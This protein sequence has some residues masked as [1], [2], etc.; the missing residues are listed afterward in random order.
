MSDIYQLFELQQVENQIRS[1]K[2]QLD[3]VLAALR[4]NEAL[5]AA[6]HRAVETA[7]QLKSY[8]G[9]QKTLEHELSTL[10]SKAKRSENRLYSGNVKNPKELS[11]LQNELKALGR[12]RNTLEDDILEIMLFVEEAQENHASATTTLTQEETLWATRQ[13]E[14]EKEKLSLATQI[15]ALMQDRKAKLPRISANALAIYKATGKKRG[16]QAMAGLKQGRCQSCQV[17]VSATKM[18]AAD[19]GSL[20]DCGSCGKILCPVR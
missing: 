14:L 2:T 19:E 17:T 11:D 20:V 7:D 9:Q 5:I 3:D 12:R 13:A 6:Q 15:N 4:N 10:N 18:K 1:Q 16:G 8:Q